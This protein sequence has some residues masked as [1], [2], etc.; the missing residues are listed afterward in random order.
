MNTVYDKTLL[1]IFASYIACFI[2]LEIIEQIHLYIYKTHTRIWKV[3]IT[4]RI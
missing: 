4:H 1:Y 3:S 2:I